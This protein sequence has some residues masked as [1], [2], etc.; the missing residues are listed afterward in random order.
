MR[1]DFDRVIDRRNTNSAKWDRNLEL[2]GTEDVLDM[3]VADMDFPCPQPVLDALRRRLDHPILGYGFP[4]ETL[5][6]AIIDRMERFYGWVVEK[7][8]ITF[9]PGV[10]TGVDAAVRALANPGD[11]IILQPPVYHPFFRYVTN[12]G[13][14][15]VNS[16]LRLENDHYLMDFDDLERCFE[17]AG[18]FPGKTHRIRGMILCSPHNPVGR[19]WTREELDRL[20]G[21]CLANDCVIVSDE[22]HCD[23]LVGDSTHT[24]T[25]SLS[26]EIAKMTI[27]LMAPSKT[28]NL[29]GLDTSFAIIPDPRLRQRFQRA[30]LGQGGVN[31]LGLVAMEAALGRETDD[32]LAQLNEYIT[33]NVRCFA[34]AVAGIPGVRLIPPE[35]PEGTY[36]AWVDMRELAQRLGLARVGGRVDDEGL[37]D[38]MIS[39]ARIASGFGYIFGPGGSGFQR[40]N[41][42]CPR[43]VVE[44]AVSR[45]EAAVRSST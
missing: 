16:Q 20:A 41:L 26:P 28:F 40:L 45:L 13:C 10:I 35:G 38:F 2:F 36:L 23:L 24:P 18:G 7:D 9:T 12:S 39:K 6:Q 14:Q 3:W 34:R 22:I 33:G 44:E 43:S 8:W 15:V 42:A 17:T 25:A 30:R 32:Y 27:T 19:V 31:V 37:R 21:I 1:Y 5:Y 29:A 11:E 4:P